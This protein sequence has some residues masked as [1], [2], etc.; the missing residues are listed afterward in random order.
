[1]DGVSARFWV[2]VFN[3]PKRGMIESIG[4]VVG[5]LMEKKCCKLFLLNWMGG[6]DGG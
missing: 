3:L 6:I 1:M 5:G 2:Q 4:Q